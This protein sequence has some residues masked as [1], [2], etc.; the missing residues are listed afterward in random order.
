MK[1][2]C[3]FI[4]LAL[5]LFSLVPTTSYALIQPDQA[6]IP[7]PQFLQLLK[8][9]QATG[10][11]VAGATFFL[12]TDQAGQEVL[13]IDGRDS[14]T[15]DEAGLIVQLSSELELPGVYL[16]EKSAPSGYQTLEEPVWIDIPPYLDA[17]AMQA[18][19]PDMNGLLDD[20]VKQAKLTPEQRDYF[21][22]PREEPLQDED[23]Q[24]I[25]R[26]ILLEINT[27][28]IKVANQPLKPE[29]VTEPSKPQKPSLPGTGMGSS[30]PWL[31]LGAGLLGLGYFLVKKPSQRTHLLALLLI[32]S[33]LISPLAASAETDAAGYHFVEGSYQSGLHARYQSAALEFS[34]GDDQPLIIGYCAD[35]AIQLNQA[36]QPE[37]ISWPQYQALTGKTFSDEQTGL[38]EAILFHS[39]PQMTFASIAELSGITAHPE[40]MVRASQLAIWSIANG[41]TF[42]QQDGVYYVSYPDMAADWD[43]S[44]QTFGDKQAISQATYQL[45]QWYLALEPY[46]TQ[47]PIIDEIITI[48]EGEIVLREYIDSFRELDLIALE[49]DYFYLFVNNMLDE[50]TPDVSW[51]PTQFS[52]LWNTA[53]VQPVLHLTFGQREPVTIDLNEA[54]RA[55]SE[56]D[57]SPFPD[58]LGM[59]HLH[60]LMRAYALANDLDPDNFLSDIT[61]FSLEIHPLKPGE[62]A[63]L[64]EPDSQP[65]LVV[66]PLE[67]IEYHHTATASL[68]FTKLLAATHQAIADVAFQLE[69]LYYPAE[70]EPVWQAYGETITSDESGLVRLDNLIPGQYRLME[71]SDIYQP[72]TED[73]LIIV[74]LLG[75]VLV[76]LT[77]QE[78]AYILWRAHDGETW[79]AQSINPYGSVSELE[80]DYFGRRS[81]PLS[82][83]PIVNTK[84]TEPFEITIIK[85]D[86]DD[87]S[88]VLAGAEFTVYRDEEA[89]FSRI[90]DEN[91][92]I[93]LTQQDFELPLQPGEYTIKETKP[94]AGYFINDTIYPLF[95]V[96]EYG[97]ITLPDNPTITI[98]NQRMYSF[99]FIKLSEGAE[100]T[101]LEGAYFELHSMEGDLIQAQYSDEHGRVQ[102]SELLPG[103]YILSEP[104]PMN[105]YYPLE[106][107]FEI[108][109]DLAGNI[110]V[111]ELIDDQRIPY[112]P[113]PD[114]DN[115]Y[116]IRNEEELLYNFRF[117]KLSTN[118]DISPLEDARFELVDDQGNM[119]EAVSDWYGL[120]WFYNLKPG[121]Y[122]LSEPVPPEGHYPLDTTFTLTIYKDGSNML[123]DNTTGAEVEL[124]DPSTIGPL[125]IIYNEVTIH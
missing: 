16:H 96:D 101:R 107:S 13:T 94:P 36:G 55:L 71:Q 89:L 50:N 9:D 122:T 42:G 123:I 109:I 92:Q 21:L 11:P 67:P 51:L 2:T 76:E 83:I 5:L 57:E 28:E 119:Q 116:V 33:L 112:S 102:F 60:S 93:R 70:G 99:E 74:D 125:Y 18:K 43:W 98:T 81:L 45:A 75:N 26:L 19:L 14:F 68:D 46:H 58:Y 20:M 69:R 117:L 30:W 10:K 72:L 91:G 105:G 73:I 113:D 31:L 25:L 41:L 108:E 88:L 115:E 1:K 78:T 110:T 15:S 22:A 23:F 82:P 77:L 47:S 121:T 54:L 12:S 62:L 118:G 80:Y 84:P 97:E 56:Q 52:A 24:A 6:D 64:Y 29:T 114:Y 65:V 35:G 3:F 100:T 32:S 39:Y 106:S 17:A 86:A 49:S 90:S 8:T 63:V 4:L 53:A 27:Q 124:L 38:L 48:P 66:T 37:L 79:Y 61:G 104:I 44:S 120:V 85:T 40:E 59:A 95:T 7:Y 111:W 103:S 34:S 87:D